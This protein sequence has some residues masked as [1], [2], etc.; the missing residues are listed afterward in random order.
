MLRLLSA[1]MYKSRTCIGALL[2]AFLAASATGE[3]VAADDESLAQS[4]WRPDSDAPPGTRTLCGGSYVEPEF[5]FADD[6][7]S[8]AFEVIAEGSSIEYLENQSLEITGPVEIRQGSRMV[9]A[10]GASLD[11]QTNEA[12]FHG[13]TEMM[14]PGLQARGRDAVIADSG[15][16]FHIQELEFVMPE[17]SMRGTALTFDQT[18][19]T[20]EFTASTLT[21][22]APGSRTWRISARSMRIAQ[23]NIFAQARGVRFD[24]LG[25]PVGYAPWVQFPASDERTTGFLF[26]TVRIND[27]FDGDEWVLPYYLNLAPNYDATIA[28][29]S[30]SKRG[31]GVDVEL[32]HRSS[33]SA[34]QLNGT[35]IHQDKRYNG[36][37]DIL[38]HD[39][40][41]PFV[42]AD[43]WFLRARQ[44]MHWGRL[45]TYVNY[46]SVSDN[47]FFI[48]LGS[49]FGERTSES[50][51][52]NAGIQYRQGDFSATVWAQRFKTLVRNF[53]YR[54]QP[55]ASLSYTPK[56]VTI[57]SVP[58]EW[59]VESIWSRFS[60]P[61]ANVVTG[62]R[63]HL[64]SS[65]AL[66][67]DASWGWARP[68][69]TIMH[70]F[71]DIDPATEPENPSPDRTI[72][73]L[74]MD[75]GL[76]IERDMAFGGRGRMPWL[77][78]LNPRVQYRY[79]P[80]R[81]QEDLPFYDGGRHRTDYQNLF[82]DRR[83]SGFDRISD[84]DEVAIGIES[85]LFAPGSGRALLTARAGTIVTLSEQS[86]TV[87]LR[88]DPPKED[89]TLAAEMS[90]QTKHWR[91][92]AT[93]LSQPEIEDANKTDQWY[94]GSQY[95]SPGGMVINLGYRR[96]ELQEI[97][98]SDIALF[99]PVLR[100]WNIFGRWHHDWGEGRL[101]ERFAGVE[102]GDCCLSIAVM[103]HWNAERPRNVIPPTTVI[104]RQIMLQFV[105][106]GLGGVGT[107]LREYLI[108]GI[109]GYRY[110][111]TNDEFADF[112][113]D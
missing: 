98:Q 23:D 38:W 102:Y 105:F 69:A 64:E 85:T 109:R 22:C 43:R 37:V 27:V 63:G 32:R 53:S 76:R 81:D 74:Q 100:R 86:V 70:T 42:A 97:D 20:R 92:D 75:L 106:H 62:D 54:R 61:R 30:I 55:E 80:Y 40:D 44:G 8:D 84:V 10:Q 35:Y 82:R 94:L 56:A 13:K 36:D 21:T 66:P 67:L 108:H 88:Q 71:Y 31:P 11:A 12:R 24:V 103:W 73:M 47:D 68:A 4:L 17:K 65:L 51:E 19:G 110:D 45:S 48:D 2:M 57:A 50:L 111:Q 14:Q 3:A 9:R 90:V 83:F 52:Q 58:I 96:R 5:L 60:H 95:A 39:S 112:D 7:P 15:N 18:G 78:G 28:P 41:E 93:W 6:A 1:A 72:Y 25:I 29:R 46:S 107:R 87:D 91:F 49:G 77:W 33:V 99:L 101:S 16:H 79:N 113:F 104:D 89:G 26:P 59:S 34:S